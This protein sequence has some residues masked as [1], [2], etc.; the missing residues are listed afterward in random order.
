[1]GDGFEAGSILCLYSM[2]KGDFPALSCARVVRC[3]LRSVD[4]DGWTCRYGPLRILLFGQEVM[5][6]STAM[7]W[8]WLQFAL[9]VSGLGYCGLAVIG[10]VVG[11]CLWKM[12]VF[13][14]RGGVGCV[15]RWLSG[16]AGRE[17]FCW[18]WE[19]WRERCSCIG[20]ICVSWWRC[21][22]LVSA[23]QPV[24]MRSAVFCTVCSLLMDVF[25]VICDHVVLAYSRMGLVIA[26]YVEAIVSCDL[27]HC[28]V[29]SAFSMFTDF[30]AFSIVSFVCSAKFSLVSSV[31]PSIFGCCIVGIVVLF[32]CRFSL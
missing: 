27:P 13:M 31:T 24:A 11:V 6:F 26:L 32:I 15:V 22:W 30:F 19:A 7:V 9:M 12:D 3:F 1:M 23:V 29:V 28:V 2:R 16:C 4:S 10:L 18:Y 21:R 14:V 25:E 8:I 20:R 5:K 17:V